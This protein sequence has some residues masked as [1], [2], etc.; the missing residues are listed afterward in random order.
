M[1]RHRTS[2]LTFALGLALVGGVPTARAADNTTV[3][4]IT[5]VR[6]L[7]PDQHLIVLSNGTRLLASQA[8]ASLEQ[9]RS[10]RDALDAAVRTVETTAG[11]SPQFEKDL[12]DLIRRL[13]SAAGTAASLG[14]IPDSA[15]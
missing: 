12:Q 4:A 1:S 5:T 10:L 3:E 11:G 2:T 7:D 13:N 15:K 6:T 9:I 8:E 14:R